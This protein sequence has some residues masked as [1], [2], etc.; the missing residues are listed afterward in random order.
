M[1]DSPPVVAHSQA[2]TGSGAEFSVGQDKFSR[3]RRNAA[4]TNCSSGL[5]I[6]ARTGLDERK[7]K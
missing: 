2:G 4:G 1:I 6:A 5:D 3:R 7:I